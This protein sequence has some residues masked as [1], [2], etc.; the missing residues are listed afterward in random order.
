MNQDLKS[1]PNIQGLTGS[2]STE[3]ADPGELK[4]PDGAAK[5]VDG[6][7]TLSGY[8][9]QKRWFELRTAPKG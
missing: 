9:A 1:H 4:V 2:Q 8:L 6:V 3:E 7:V 5:W